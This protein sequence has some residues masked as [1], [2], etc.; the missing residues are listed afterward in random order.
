MNRK[1]FT[2]VEL[3]ATIVLLALVVGI[4]SYAI[5]NII[6]SSKEKNYNLLISNVKDA[7]ELYYEECRYADGN[8]SGITC[9][10][11]ADGSYQVTLG[12]LVSYGYLKGN[13]TIKSSTNEQ[14]IG[15]YTILNPKDN[16]SIASCKIKITYTSG[17]INVSAITTTG[18]CPVEY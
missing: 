7:S 13:G 9:T 2:L 5:T 16:K 12:N 4:S 10:V 1:G 14:N 15:K 18:S 6:K 17:K 8:N 11:N 3:L